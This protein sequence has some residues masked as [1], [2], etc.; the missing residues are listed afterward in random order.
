MKTTSF[1]LED[2]TC[3]ICIH[4]VE[5][6]LNKE[7]GVA[8]AKVLF[9]SSK[10]NVEF[11]EAKTSAGKLADDVLISCAGAYYSHENDFY[12]ISLY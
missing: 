7:D 5:G 2:L 9:N 12:T 6:V 11:D 3:P 4:K 10:V 8:A 1:Q